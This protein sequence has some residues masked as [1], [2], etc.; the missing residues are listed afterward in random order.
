M[1]DVAIAALSPERL[2]ALQAEL[3]GELER[4]KIENRLQY[5]RPYPKQAEFHAAGA[6][7]RERLLM[8]GNQLGKTL[9]GGFEAA[10]HVTG[11]YP[12]WW[13]GKRF[14]RPVV[15][16][17]CGVTGE[18]VRDTVQRVLIGRPG[19]HG[20]GAIPKECI[21]DLVP[22]RGAADLLD[23]IKVRHVSGDYSSIGLKSYNQGREKFQGETLD[24]VWFDEE[25]PIEIYLE[26]LTRTN[27][28]NNPVWITF[29]PLLGMSETVRRFLMEP[30]PDRHITTMTIDD[31]QHYSP[32]EREKIIASYPAHELEARTKGIPTLGS[33]RIFPVPE[34]SIKCESFELPRH[35]TRIIG[36]DF[37]WTIL[38]PLWS[39]LGTATMTLCMSFGR[40][41][42][43]N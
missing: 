21:G 25:P 5:Y 23:S 15:A 20:T 16:W 2:A 28:G 1:S 37:G 8:A 34:A 9:A 19:Q 43:G 30:S 38:Q 10:M 33:G 27:V 32:E 4:R 36:I 17:A 11:R 40:T 22:S 7:C 13:R 29:T 14:D 6:T 41:V 35:W 3:I 12:E 42:L 18:V 39:W 26:G 24:F 31:V